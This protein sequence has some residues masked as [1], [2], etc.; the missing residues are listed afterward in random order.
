MF[1][2]ATK[3]N[4]V[5]K[6]RDMMR[7]Q[8]CLVLAKYMASLLVLSVLCA[9]HA[10]RSE[11]VTN[12]ILY[13]YQVLVEQKCAIVK[14]NFNHR[15]RYVSH[16][17]I[18]SGTELRIMLRPID[19]R[20]FDLDG[21]MREALR[22][23]QDRSLA[24]KAIQY[25]ARIAEGPTLTI[26]F[27]RPVNFDAAGGA[28][29]Q[30]LVFSVTN[31]KT[32][33]ACKPVFPDRAA[34]GWGTVATTREGTS[35]VA[36]ARRPKPVAIPPVP[37]TPDAPTVAAGTAPVAISA[38]PPVNGPAV[39]GPTEVAGAGGKKELGASA[40]DAAVATL[41]GEAREALK[42]GKFSLAIA[43][44]KKAVQLPENRRSPEARELLGV[45]YQKDRQPAAARSVYEDYLRRYP[46]GEGSEGVRQR[47]QAIE[48]A[49]A[50]PALTL[51]APTTIGPAAIDGGG[52]PGVPIGSGS[53]W[54][55]SGSL[56]SF[57]IRDDTRSVMRD[58]TL[59]LN[60]NA[61]KDDHQVH[62]NTLL[63]S[64]DL[65]AAWGNPDMKSKF[66]F[67]G[68]E[69]NRFGPEEA[70]I[71]GI[72]ALFL[73]TTIKDWDTNFRI[74]RQTRNTGGILGRFDGAV[75]NYQVNPWFGLTAV[76]GS[77][78]EFRSDLPFKDDRYFYGGSLNFGP[79]RGF[80]ADVYAIEQM[81]RSILD[82]QAVGTELHYNDA[83]KS[84]FATVDYDTHFNE[85]DA[86]IFTGTWT[87][88]DKS[89]LR[90]GADYRKAPFLTT[91]N[92][93]LGQ[94][95]TTLY[96]L[97]KVANTQLWDIAKMAIDRTATYQSSNIGYSRALTDKLQI[98]LDFTQAHID[99]TI[100][101]FNV[102]G[103]PDM[104]D[105]FYY[106]AQLVGTSLFLPNDLYTA[107]FRYSDLK[108]SQNYAV[109]LSTRYPWTEN[110]RIQPRIVGGYTQGKGTP[111]EEYTLLPSVLIDYFLRKDLNFEIEV[112][113]RWTWRTQGTT[114]SSENEFLIT[115]GFRLDF[116]ADAQNNCLTPSVFCRTSTQALK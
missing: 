4:L 26:L 90:L 29:F 68:T 12:R 108:D 21:S 48:T 19:P 83:N 49:D 109:D 54:S 14:I 86:A 23:P 92:A 34:N 102:N 100:A 66:R 33:N 75:V 2:P 3:S 114:R 103:T 52:Q 79:Y 111:F 63:T 42:Q 45:A 38:R 116:Y 56:S 77:P 88:A 113:E 71:T 74:G 1:T 57:Y 105:E 110:L 53:Y 28:D 97:L 62:Q 70:N 30:S 87:F 112:G 81:D 67:S 84:M 73:D 64:F 101:S 24:I 46:N 85:L 9:S 98:N 91:W 65:A 27:D 76:G 7:Q 69:E 8:T 32:G 11:P 106:S 50:P 31:T 5:R 20:Q 17:P 10:A 35:E 61:T 96:D 15:I 18:H 82:R 60:L 13:G 37:I 25:E 80:D 95:Y 94:P 16:F 47:L 39:S 6:T 104:G 72:S 51:R 107:A 22:P 59:A 55:V 99:G 58:P 115:A 40:S 93:I 78:V 36:V 89:V 44:L 43:Q 41:L